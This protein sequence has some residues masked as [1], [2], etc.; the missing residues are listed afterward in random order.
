MVVLFCRSFDGG[1]RWSTLCES[2]F[3]QNAESI[4]AALAE[5]VSEDSSLTNMQDIE[6]VSQFVQ[7]E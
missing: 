2:Y 3:A 5:A 1:R 7:H 4:S 6:S